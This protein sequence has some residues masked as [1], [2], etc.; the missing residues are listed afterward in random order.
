MHR[1]KLEAAVQA[2]EIFAFLSLFLLVVSF[3]FA[4]LSLQFHYALLP[5]SLWG[6]LPKT[7]WQPSMGHSLVSPVSKPSLEPGSPPANSRSYASISW[8]MECFC[9]LFPPLFSDSLLNPLQF[10]SSPQGCS[11]WAPSSFSITMFLHHMEQ[12]SGLYHHLLLETVSMTP[13]REPSG[14][15]S[16]IA[17]FSFSFSLAFSL[18]LSF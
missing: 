7:S 14:F 3:S 10:S 2:H 9:V 8:T 15:P 6:L 5:C 1:Q 11:E 4:D 18:L 12:V 13:F 17:Y 16:H